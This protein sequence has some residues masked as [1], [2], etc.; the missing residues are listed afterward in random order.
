MAA[1][2]TLVQISKL[3]DDQEFRKP[4]YFQY[5]SSGSQ[6]VTLT[7]TS[8]QNNC[9]STT[10]TISIEN[11][12]CGNNKILVCHKDPNNPSKPQETIC[13]NRSSLSTHLAHGDC[14]GSCPPS[15]AKRSGSS[16]NE[17][18]GSE[19]SNEKLT[20]KIIL[21]N[22]PNPFNQSTNIEFQLPQSEYVKLEV[23]NYLGAKITTLFE[24]MAEEQKRYTISFRTE[25]L[26]SGIYFYSIQTSNEKIIQKMLLIK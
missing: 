15:A 1:I 3:V 11:T 2:S 14:I 5:N 9:N 20:E 6:N 4:D 18:I 13:I 26:P 19:I 7:V 10:K 17:N 16:D 21:K 8:S 23:Y 12:S 25:T 22:A 24:G